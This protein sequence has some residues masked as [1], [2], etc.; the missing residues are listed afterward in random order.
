M[1]E[2]ICDEPSKRDRLNQTQ[3]HKYQ[4]KNCVGNCTHIGQLNKAKI[5]SKFASKRYQKHGP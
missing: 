2:A 5:Q 3:W 4:Q 1:Y